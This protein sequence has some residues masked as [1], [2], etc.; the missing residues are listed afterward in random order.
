MPTDYSTDI[1]REGFSKSEI[2]ERIS[3]FRIGDS[4]WI[5]KRL[6]S[7]NEGKAEGIHSVVKQICRYHIVFQLDSGIQRSLNN[8]D[9]MD[10]RLEKESAFAS[11]NEEKAMDDVFHA[12]ERKENNEENKNQ[13]GS[14]MEYTDI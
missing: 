4:V 3:K 1:R 6:I 9:C 8:F 7:E 5:P 13:G 2:I 11:Y 10:V 12:M 14:D